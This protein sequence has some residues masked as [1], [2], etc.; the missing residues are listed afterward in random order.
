MKDKTTGDKQNI[1]IS[2]RNTMIGRE[3]SR[4][5]SSNLGR[6]K[7]FTLGNEEF[8]RQTQKI[9]DNGI[10]PAADTPN[11][12]RYRKNASRRPGQTL[13]ENENHGVKRLGFTAPAQK[14][15]MGKLEMNRS[16]VDKYKLKSSK[17]NSEATNLGQSFRRDTN[18]TMENEDDDIYDE[19]PASGTLGRA[20]ARQMMKFT[21]S[22]KTANGQNR[23][24]VSKFK[25][26]KESL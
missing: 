18:V 21:R 2:L 17:R 25:T 8:L 13:P 3:S 11:V 10:Q 9:L 5:N 26:S 20:F 24:Y 15:F 7:R 19:I 6:S 22:S 12:P 23:S 16:L 14:D 4:G 1:G